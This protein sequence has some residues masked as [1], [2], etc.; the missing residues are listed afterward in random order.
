MDFFRKNKDS[1]PRHELMLLE[2]TLFEEN[3]R[4]IKEATVVEDKNFK[5]YNSIYQKAIRSYKEVVDLE[6]VLEDF[7][8]SRVILFGDYH[9]LDQS[10]RS[11]IRVLRAYFESRKDRRMTVALEAIQSRFQKSLQE[12]FLGKI[13]Q[14]EFVKRIGFKK[15]WFFDLWSNYE[16]IF[17]FLIYHHIPLFGIDADS[18][19]AETKRTCQDVCKVYPDC[20]PGVNELLNN[21]LEIVWWG[22]DQI[23]VTGWKAGSE[24]CVL[25]N[26][27]VEITE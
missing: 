6:K 1:S 7:D 12:F 17:D 3:K 8:E 10:Q 24:D 9:T 13:K 21:F 11:F 19:I 20:H 5:K 25:I 27:G 15:H 18:R 16:I 2:K 26:E 4:I 14:E 22:T 23:Q